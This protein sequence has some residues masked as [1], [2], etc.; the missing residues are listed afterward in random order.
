MKKIFVVSHVKDEADIIESFLRYNLCYSD[1]I[2][3]NEGNR[4]SDKTIEIIDKLIEEGLPIHRFDDIDGGRDL[5]VDKNDYGG[6]YDKAK[7]TLARHAVDCFGADLVLALDA[8]EFLYHIDGINP[9][10]ALEAMD[11]DIEY[12]LN[13]R[14][15]IY[16]H[17]PEASK[18]FMPDNYT[19]YRNPALEPGKGSFAGTALI[20]KKLMLEKDAYLSSGAHN[21]VYPPRHWNTV[22]LYYHSK[23]VCAHYPIRS[24]A[25]VMLM[26]VPRWMKVQQTTLVSIREK[27]DKWPQGMVFNELRDTGDISHDSIFKFSLEYGIQIVETHISTEELEAIKKELGENLTIYG[28]MDVSFCEDKLILKYTASLPGDDRKVFLRAVLGQIDQT[29]TNYIELCDRMSK[30]IDELKQQI[31]ELSQEEAYEER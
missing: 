3:I 6:I 11:E 18:G 21:L 26:S 17:E 25:Q 31:N 29:V 22:G 4:S 24:K 16:Q 19:N 15:Y 13:W 7:H 30:Q 2:I 27:N 14:S 8:D 1:G 12:R 23:L 28:P 10:D 5:H 9:R 20:S